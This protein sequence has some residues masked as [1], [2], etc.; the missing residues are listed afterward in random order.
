MDEVLWSGELADL[1]RT[2]A[3][4][5][6]QKEYLFLLS[7]NNVASLSASELKGK[8]FYQSFSSVSFLLMTK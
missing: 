2:I 4:A 8:T 6:F 1:E 7:Q 3:A 5:Q